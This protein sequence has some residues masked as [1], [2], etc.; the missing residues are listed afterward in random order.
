MSCR[1]ISTRRR[2]GGE[3]ARPLSASE[4]LLDTLLEIAI[5]GAFVAPRIAIDAVT[6]Q[7]SAAIAR[8]LLW[9]SALAAIAA[10]A[11]GIAA[12]VG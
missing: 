7:Q 2:A 12:F 11:S 8:R 9:T 3:P 1:R 6:A 5:R 10:V 4:R